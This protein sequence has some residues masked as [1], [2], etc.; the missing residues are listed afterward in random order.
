MSN[1]TIVSSGLERRIASKEG[2]QLPRRLA[3]GS[4]PKLRRKSAPAHTH[5][6]DIVHTTRSGERSNPVMAAA[7]TEKTT[8]IQNSCL[9]LD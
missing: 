5:I 2:E 7:R 1:R 4:A 8:S 9:E 3:D 6:H